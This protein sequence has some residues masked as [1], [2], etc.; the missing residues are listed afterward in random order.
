MS[1]RHGIVALA[2]RVRHVTK[3]SLT[4]ASMPA[5]AHE[6]TIATE[7]ARPRRPIPRE[8]TSVSH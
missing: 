5:G 4:H 3:Q 2:S 7:I 1:H 6:E 8:T